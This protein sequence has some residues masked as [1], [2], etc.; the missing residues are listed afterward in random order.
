[1]SAVVLPDCLPK[2]RWREIPGY[3]NYLISDFGRVWLRKSRYRTKSH[4]LKQSLSYG[5]RCVVLGVIKP[6]HRIASWRM[7][8]VHRLVL[9]VF[10][11]P[12][13][14]GMWC[15]HWDGNPLNNRLENLR[16]G[17]PKENAADAIRHGTFVRGSKNGC[18]K[19]TESAVREIHR[20]RKQGWILDRL[21]RRFG[22]SLTSIWYVVRGRTWKHVSR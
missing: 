15:C 13:P 10:V 19:L 1:M 17:T 3:P 16:W 18:A 21:A 6:G 11:G 5:R 12:C 4:L 2:E 22:V 20:L 14:L 7:F 8:L 9:E